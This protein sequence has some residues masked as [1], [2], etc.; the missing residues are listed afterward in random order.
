MAKFVEIR[1][2]RASRSLLTGGFDFSGRGIERERI[3]KLPAEQEPAVCARQFRLIADFIPV[4]SDG[5]HLLENDGSRL[6]V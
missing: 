3:E 4:G 5:I 2:C 1:K 6:L